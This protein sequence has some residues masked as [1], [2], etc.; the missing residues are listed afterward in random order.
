MVPLSRRGAGDI[1]NLGRRRAPRGV[2]ILWTTAPQSIF[3]ANVTRSERGCVRGCYCLQRRGERAPRD[4]WAAQGN[5]DDHSRRSLK[6]RPQ[7]Q[8]NTTQRSDV[9]ASL[10]GRAHQQSEDMTSRWF[11]FTQSS[12]LFLH[13]CVRRAPH[14]DFWSPITSARLINTRQSVRQKIQSLAHRAGPFSQKVI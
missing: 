8:P 11:I 7:V 3:L 13:L 10:V 12:F 14:A 4:E 1:L 6:N 2:D 5:L 9:L